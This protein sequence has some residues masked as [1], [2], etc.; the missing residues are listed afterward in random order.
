MAMAVKLR[1]MFRQFH[2][3]AINVLGRVCEIE[4]CSH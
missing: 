1:D 2:G 3:T 4:D